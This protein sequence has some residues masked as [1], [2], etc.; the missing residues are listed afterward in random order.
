MG[1]LDG[2][3]R[4]QCLH[5]SLPSNRFRPTCMFLNR[6]YWDKIWGSIPHRTRLLAGNPWCDYL[7]VGEWLVGRPH[8]VGFWLKMVSGRAIQPPLDVSILNGA[9][10]SE[11]LCHVRW[12]PS[13]MTIPSRE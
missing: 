4:L 12:D 13:W 5:G 11:A 1:T 2:K 9:D 10:H 3:V 7:T 6:W 8:G